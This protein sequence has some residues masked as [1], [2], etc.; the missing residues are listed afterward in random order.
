VHAKV[1]FE[2]LPLFNNGLWHP[3]ASTLPSIGQTMMAG[4]PGVAA[5]RRWRP[6][7]SGSVRLIGILQKPN[8]N[9]GACTVFVNGV[10]HWQQPMAAG[11]IVPHAFDI[12]LCDLPPG[13]F[14][15]MAVDGTAVAW[16]VQIVDEPCTAFRPD[17]PIGPQFTNA[18][19]AVQREKGAAILAQINALAD[20]KTRE[21]TVPGGDY[22]FSGGQTYPHV[23]N[24][25]D[26][27]I[28][29]RGATF[30]FDPPLV[31]GLE[32]DDCRN[33]TVRGLTIDCDPL[34]FFQGQIVAIDPATN[35]VTAMLM[36]GYET[37]DQNGL[38]AATNGHRTVSY[39]RPD[40]SYVRNGIIGCTWSR[41]PN[42][43]LVDI[44][45]PS[46]GVQVGDYLAC[47]IRTGQELRS[48]GCGGM[49]YEDVNIYAGGGMAVLDSAGPGGTIYRRV[50]CTR[51]P[52]TNRLHAFGADGWHIA[53]DD[54]G[55]VLDRCEGAYFADDEVNLHGVFNQI[56][57]KLAPDHYLLSSTYGRQIGTFSPGQ[58]LNFWSYVELEP[59]GSAKVAS[60]SYSADSEAWDVMLDRNVSLPDNVLI[61]THVQNSAHFIIKNCWFHDTGQ[62]F[63]VNGAPYGV[64][65]NTTFQNIGGGIDIDN[66]SWAGN[67]TEGAFPTG[68][69]FRSNR[70]INCADSLMVGLNPGGRS[71]RGIRRTTPIKDVTITGNYFEGSEGIV[72]ASL[73]D[74]LKIENNVFNQPFGGADWHGFPVTDALFGEPVTAPIRLETVNNAVLANNVVYD[75]LNRTNGRTVVLGPLTTNVLVDGSAQWDTVADTFSSW[76]PEE[77][78]GR[79]WS[80]G[81]LD[82]AVAAGASYVSDSF[83]PLPVFENGVWTPSAG[84]NHLPAIGIIHEHAGATFA[85]VRRWRC[86]VAGAAKACGVV[87][88]E[89]PANGA[90]FSVFVDGK[91]Q[92]TVDISDGDVH[93]F[94]MPLDDLKIGSAVD[95]VVGSKGAVA[96][97]DTVL[98]AKILVPHGRIGRSLR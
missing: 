35:T 62:R 56:V 91:R 97:N 14:V 53:G 48:I 42:S 50:R 7:H 51:R 34:P 90:T 25:N 64:I 26:V 58:T 74:G 47:V 13:A 45:A 9:A 66:E 10:A 79:G 46:P 6:A 73:V 94:S 39:Y 21:F 63:L 8:R 41:R 80:F 81:T 85:A 60:A 98:F 28:D 84:G 68:T 19:K 76:Y 43:N 67:W 23:Q 65:E 11:D 40:G 31:Q 86:T 77:Q 20:G 55:A 12:L 49:V 30:W 36:P 69:I 52:G 78:G 70:V 29:A 15:D 96:D 5:I 72:D 17:L 16:S 89:G 87:Q 27:V 82:S 38:L 22:R 88:T 3:R 93:P 59:L 24:L 83:A 33:V 75:P 95:L 2:R 71:G 32:F 54:K 44:T 92:G 18:Q 4:T 37:T 61:D 1:R 57:K